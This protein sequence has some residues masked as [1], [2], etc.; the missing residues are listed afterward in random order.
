M[1]KLLTFAL[2]ALML[3]Q[4]AT[5]V[6]AEDAA[7]ATELT[8]AEGSH[9][10]LTEN[11]YIDGIDGT[12]TV[13]ELKAEFTEAIDIAGKNDDAFVATDDSIGNYKAL[14]Y[15]DVNRDG[16]ANLSDV[17]V[18]LQKIAGW[19]TDI[20]NDAADVNKSGDTDLL[21]VTKMLKYAAGWD[22]ISLGNVRMVFENK[23]ITAEND[24]DSFDLFFTS[25]MNK[26]GA[27]ETDHTGEFSYKM[28]LARNESESCQALLY[29]VAD[30]EGLSAEL[31]DFVYEYGDAVI[32]SKLE[33]VF[34]YPNAHLLREVDDRVFNNNAYIN[35]D[36][37]EV[38]LPMADTFE[39]RADRMQHFVI[40][41]TSEKDSP[42]G[43]Y[44]AS[45]NFRDA[46]GNLI[47]TA[48][49]YAYVW[50]FT[51][52]D[53]PYS[54]SLFGTN[55][56]A[57]P[58]YNQ[59]PDYYEHMLE[60]NLSS[61]NLPVSIGSDEADAYLDDPR[62]TTFVVDGCES[63]YSGRMNS[64]DEEV[65]ACWEKL[66]SNPEW[67]E[68]HV[69]Y[70]TDEPGASDFQEII[71]TYEYDA[72]LIGTTEF[73]NMTQV[74]TFYI[75]NEDHSANID[76]IER[77]KPYINVWCPSANAFHSYADGGYWGT[78]YSE[79]KYG[80]WE[81]R[82]Q[83]LRERG[84]S[85]W[86]Y[87][88]AAPESQYPNFFT[89]YQGCINRVLMWQ[90]YHYDVEALLYYATGENWDEITKHKFAIGSGDG[91][92]QYPGEKWGRTGP[93]ASWRLY[94]VRDGFDDF[95][96]LCIA[97]EIVGKD[98]VMKIVT[99]LTPNMVKFCEDYR[100]L[101]MARDTIAKIILE[102]K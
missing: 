22:D 40:T 52:P 70:F 80:S 74:L 78:R 47:K 42:A 50:D 31:T 41:V 61:Y 71:D 96:Y 66:K 27:N 81:T 102:N 92:L 35:D 94:Q 60:H 38:L 67:M 8:L 100:D 86:W 59:Y 21:D 1:K 24:S 11:G 83:K 76:S 55:H 56:Y 72:K 20:N 39:V 5:A 58:E 88:L 69:F 89:Y 37:P 73:R 98:E 75:N 93:C 99:D 65:V 101:E 95:D 43:M 23:A 57:T 44:K 62:M 91:N 9:L 18:I 97:E 28:K 45:L 49:V 12:I 6:F 32:E 16:K 54:D 85:L 53:T 79:N 51:L 90:Q 30:A 87:V 7:P 68:K 26:L 3:S 4:T 84:D 33:W 63:K 46:D 14:I 29:S 15:G 48:D 64:T 36:L 17:S 2:A 10:T 19:D 34:Y 13:G 25:M 77:Y 82:A